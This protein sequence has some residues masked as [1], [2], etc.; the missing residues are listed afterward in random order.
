[1][2]AQPIRDGSSKVCIIF[3]ENK[4]YELTCSVVFDAVEFVDARQD[5]RG[6]GQRGWPAADTVPRTVAKRRDG[7][8][9]VRKRLRRVG[10]PQEVEQAIQLVLVGD[11]EGHQLFQA[12]RF[13][14]QFARA[15]STAGRV[16]FRHH[17]RRMI[18]QIFGRH[19]SIE[20]ETLAPSNKKCYLD[21]NR[22]TNG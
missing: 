3:L 15:T 17:F 9:S 6:A 19:H 8:G 13:V 1:M 20:R 11:V 16:V 18:Q 14:Q 12:H 10:S 4:S 22:S 2:D 7:A 5:G 21:S